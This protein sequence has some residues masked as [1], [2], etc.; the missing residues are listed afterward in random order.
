MV[1]ATGGI[2]LGLLGPGIC[3][4][5]AGYRGAA[6]G[7][8]SAVGVSHSCD[9]NACGWS[10]RGSGLGSTRSR[11]GG[12]ATNHVRPRP[13][14]MD[15]TARDVF[16]LCQLGYLPVPKELEDG[17]ARRSIGRGRGG[18]WRGGHCLGF[19][20]GT[21]HLGRLVGVG[22][23]ADDGGHSPGRLLR[24]P[25]AA[26]LRRRP[27][28]A[29]GL[30]GGHGDRRLRRCSADLVLGPVVAK[31]SSSSVI[32]PNRRSSDGAGAALAVVRFPEPDDLLRLD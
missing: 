16:E 3:T 5:P 10:L 7:Q 28:A 2:Q 13:S 22:S 21:T 1:W 11:N 31:P 30:V 14:V 20:L 26:A 15:G 27:R 32:T 4:I 6:D 18:F 9:W 8:P 29:G 17:F 23:P 12:R 25:G 24:L 19:H